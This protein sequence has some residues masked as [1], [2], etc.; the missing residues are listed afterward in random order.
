MVYFVNNLNQ[1]IRMNVNDMAHVILT[2]T[3]TGDEET[4]VCDDVWRICSDGHSISI[5]SSNNFLYDLANTTC[6]LNFNEDC[7][8]AITWAISR[9]GSLT[10]AAGHFVREGI[11]LFML[12]DMPSMTVMHQLEIDKSVISATAHIRIVEVNKRVFIVASRV[13][14]YVDILEI[15]DSSFMTNFDTIHPV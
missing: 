14:T 4:I 15:V 5:F 10:V 13:S 9:R 11:I 7:G 1:L 12:V 8:R 3:V 6:K 2:D